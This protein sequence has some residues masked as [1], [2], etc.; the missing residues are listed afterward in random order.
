MHAGEDLPHREALALLEFRQQP[1]VLSVVTAHNLTSK[2][3]RPFPG[4]KW[5]DCEERIDRATATTFDTRPAARNDKTALMRDAI[6]ESV[7]DVFGFRR[8]PDAV[9]LASHT[10]VVSPAWF[11]LVGNSCGGTER[12]LQM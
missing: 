9:D 8:I 11:P 3:R 10:T 6:R 5:G 4:G 12:G 2:K 1:I 7:G